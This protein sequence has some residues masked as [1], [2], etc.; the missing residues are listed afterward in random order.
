MK[1]LHL[2]G[3]VLATVLL[4]AACVTHET[5]LRETRSALGKGRQVTARGAAIMGMSS[6][7]WDDKWAA[8]NLFERAAAQDSSPNARFNL[9]AGY[10]ATGR[11]AD[12]LPIYASVQIDG[13]NASAQT[14]WEQFDD[15]VKVRRVNL[16]EE[17]ARRIAQIISTPGYVERAVPPIDYPALAVETKTEVEGMP[18]F[19]RVTDRKSLELDAAAR[20]IKGR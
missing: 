11:V 10:H 6:M 3:A 13:L 20:A 16:S 18:T 9:A 7:T 4:T 2:V 19:G 14:S 5:S 12:A 17:S 8:T 15:S 1:S